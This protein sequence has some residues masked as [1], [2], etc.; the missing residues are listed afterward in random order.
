MVDLKNYDIES[1]FISQL[2]KLLTVRVI[3]E[4]HIVS[5]IVK[6]LMKTK[7]DV[8]V[9]AYDLKVGLVVE[10]EYKGFERMGCEALLIN[11]AWVD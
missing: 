1:S 4:E 10:G 3:G 5:N 11:I 9:I 2:E 7:E 6:E 8:T